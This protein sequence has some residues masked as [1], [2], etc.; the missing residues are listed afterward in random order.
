[1]RWLPAGAAL[2]VLFLAAPL[3]CAQPKAGVDRGDN[4]APSPR[5]LELLAGGH[6]MF[7][8]GR[9]CRRDADTMGCTNPVFTGAQLAPAWRLSPHWSL[10][11][12]AAFDWSGEND[13]A[14]HSMWQAFAQGRW[15]PWGAGSVEPWLGVSSGVM[16]ATDTLDQAPVTGT[17]SVTQYAPA[18]GLAL[19]ANFALG[20]LLALGIETRGVFTAFGD[21]PPLGNGTA[22]HYGDNVWLWIGV[23]LTFR[24]DMSGPEVTAAGTAPERF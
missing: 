18:E 20:Q 8:F 2:A 19:G 3:V 24:P 9:V 14:K 6:V 12:M 5:P 11:A 10:G 1:M 7:A 17:G 23:S 13:G 21:A 16:A 15:R 4:S 22:R